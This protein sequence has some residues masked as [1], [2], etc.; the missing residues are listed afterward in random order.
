MKIK[1]K[2]TVTSDLSLMSLTMCSRISLSLSMN[3]ERKNNESRLSRSIDDSAKMTRI[4][5]E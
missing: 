3:K 2:E 1:K 5:V 4:T